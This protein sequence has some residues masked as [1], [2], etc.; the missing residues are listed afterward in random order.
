MKIKCWECEKEIDVDIKTKWIESKS[1]YNSEALNP[2]INAWKRFYCDSC[3]K[4][5]KEQMAINKENYIKLKIKMSYE[6][7]I[8]IL[9][10]QKIDIYEYEEAM[11]AV[12]EFAEENPDKFD[13]SYE[14]IA[15]IILINEGVSIK[16]Q[17]KVGKYRADFYLSDFKCILEIDGERHEGKLLEDSNRDIKIRQILGA[18]WEV[19]RIPTGYLE[20]NA[21]MLLK[22]LLE[23]KKLKQDTR[24]KNGGIIPS[25]YSKRDKAKS[26]E[27]ERIVSKN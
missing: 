8:G 19:V 11:K 25:T 18:E 17:Q 5:V 26:N 16:L 4:E 24:N 3:E 21:K 7:A 10:T 20:Q 22:A 14:M 6:R 9:E 23:L 15:A 2:P 27:V 1:Y 13:S 12:K